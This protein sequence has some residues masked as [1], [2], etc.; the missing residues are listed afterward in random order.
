MESREQLAALFEE[1]AL[2]ME[3]EGEN[4]FKIRAIQNAA[5]ALQA[6]PMP[7]ADFVAL[8]PSGF[9]KGLI[10]KIEE[11]LRTGAL[12][13]L[14]QLRERLPPEFL[15]VMR[16]PGL[17]PK[18]ARLLRETLQI[19]SLEA[20]EKAC[21]DDRLLAIKGFGAKSQASILA[22]IDQLKRFAGSF[23]RDVAEA[24]LRIML[25]H[26]Q[27]LFPATPF[28][29]AGSMRRGREIVRDLDLLV[30]SDLPAPIMKA[31]V[32]QPGVVRVLAEGETKSSILFKSGIQADLRVVSPDCFG[33][34]LCYFTGSKE[35]N[36]RLRGLAQ[37]KGLR[38]NEYGV[39][40]EEKSPPMATEEE[41]YAALGLPF[42][43][44]ELREDLGE[45]EWAAAGELPQLLEVSGIR[46][47]VHCHTTSSDGTTDV[48][49]MARAA[50]DLGWRWLGIADHSRSS[51]YAHG[52]PIE[53]VHQQWREIDE[54]NRV[55]AADGFRVLKGVECD[56][57]SDGSLDYPP[58]L[59]AG[60]DFV[61]VSIHSSNRLTADEMTAR[62]ERALECPFA[63]ILGHLTGRLLL[64]RE[65]FQLHMERV[66]SACRRHRTILEIN[67]SPWRLDVDWR[68]IRAHRG[69][70]LQY[71]IGP[72]AH[73]PEGL[74]CLRF[75]VDVARKG[76]LGPKDVLNTG[77]AEEFLARIRD[78]RTR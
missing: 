9:G 27:P 20:L 12:D 32:G 23:R 62:I 34:A 22:G 74:A 51:V 15:D 38:L 55:L 53:R 28:V 3:L 1:L 30:A 10:G 57:L 78:R 48:L 26:L 47:A 61:I 19:E 2:L 6:T 54:A 4:P 59:L 49:T 11:Y 71:S 44:P 46:G 76:A 72:D 67:A 37:D 13:E 25:D 45:I 41:V 75:G 14:E 73:S 29:V 66:L 60:F 5:R 68:V 40:K 42:I 43:P 35:H 18:K 33:A 39:F 64:E 17:G 16:V 50:R 24:A 21:R 7:L 77:S 36:T 70:G 63:D 56:I 65:P 69:S 58:D 31:F 8:P 52:M